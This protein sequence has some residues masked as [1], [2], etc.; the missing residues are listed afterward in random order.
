[1]TSMSDKLLDRGKY[2]CPV[3]KKVVNLE[4]DIK[5]PES[6]N[7]EPYK[8]FSELAS[9]RIECGRKIGPS[10]K[11]WCTIGPAM[12]KLAKADAVALNETDTDE[13]PGFD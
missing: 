7:W 4:S 11:Y 10:C 9:V 5:P 2:T 3:T 1:M 13:R 8:F 12:D 6:G